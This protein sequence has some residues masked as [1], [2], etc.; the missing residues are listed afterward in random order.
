MHLVSL[1]FARYS[2][3]RGASVKLLGKLLR[4]DLINPND[5]IPFLL[6]LQ[7]DVGVDG[8]RVDALKLLMTEL[9]KR[10][11]ILS[12]K[13]GIGIKLSILRL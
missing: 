2:Q 13:V 9:E 5:V 7:G 1:R 12:Q 8:V 6:A 3:I 4:Q 11:G 10:P